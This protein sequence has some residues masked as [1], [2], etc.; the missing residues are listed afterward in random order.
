MTSVVYVSTQFIVRVGALFRD[1]K[2]VGRCILRALRGFPSNG[3][4][5]ENL[6]ER[7]VYSVPPICHLEIARLLEQ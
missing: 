2:W 7:E 6:E 3:H 1:D 5:R 4:W